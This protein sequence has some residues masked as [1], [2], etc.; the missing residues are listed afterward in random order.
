ME[1]INKLYGQIAEH[2]LYLQSTD[3]Q[4]LKAAECNYTVPQDV[5]E[6]SQ[7]TRQEIDRLRDE[8]QIIEENLT[9]EEFVE[10]NQF[11]EDVKLKVKQELD[12]DE[13]A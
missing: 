13:L 3:Y 7:F 10:Y 9:N 5:I 11:V 2:K 8:I 6:K 1:E 12:A 4:R